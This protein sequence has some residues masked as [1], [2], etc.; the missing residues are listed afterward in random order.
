[1]NIFDSIIQTFGLLSIPFLSL[2]AISLFIVSERSVYFWIHRVRFKRIQFWW[3]QIEWTR[4]RGTGAYWPKSVRKSPLYPLV[5]TF[6]GHAA[7]SSESRKRACE[8]YVTRWISKAQTRI[9]LLVTLAS[10]APL[11][12][13]A[14]TALGIVSTL[15]TL[16]AHEQ[17]PAP[18]IWASGITEAI[19]ATVLGLGISIV[20]L[21]FIRIFNM[22]LDKM[23]ASAKE[24][25]AEMEDDLSDYIGPI[26]ILERPVTPVPQSQFPANVL[27]PS[28]AMKRDDRLTLQF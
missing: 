22:N 21:L 20:L 17:F 24:I 16:Q 3:H 12:G 5:Q 28:F 18:S 14:G 27:G 15:Q 6:L 19:L 26:T 2:G 10:I 23:T 13:L 25:F 8:A 11:I 1:M 7:G 4:L 9:K